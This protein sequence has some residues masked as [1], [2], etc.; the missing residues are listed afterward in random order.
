M[1]T[2][3][4]LLKPRL[5]RQA[6]DRLVKH[7]VGRPALR[8]ALHPRDEALEE[9]RYVRLLAKDAACRRQVPGVDAAGL[10]MGAQ[11]LLRDVGPERD[12]R[13]SEEFLDRN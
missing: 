4:R 12:R 5:A 6:A 7:A 10:E 8:T 2:I 13:A 3:L 11:D 1:T 9:F